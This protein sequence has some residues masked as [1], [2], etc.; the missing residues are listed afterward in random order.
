MKGTLILGVNNCYETAT[1]TTTG[2][3]ASVLPLA[4]SKTPIIAQTARTTSAAEFKVTA[5]LPNPRDIGVVT[6]A[7]HN[8]NRVAT[9]Q[10]KTY[11]ADTLINDSGV[12][13]PWCYLAE[14]E[15]YWNNKIFS[16]SIIN[17][18]RIANS[19]HTATYFLPTNLYA[20]NVEIT[21]T[22]T[23]N[24]DGFIEFGRIFI[25]DVIEP[26]YNAE[27]GD[28]SWGQ[29]DFSELQ[30]TKRHIKYAYRY[31]TIRT[32]AAAFKWLDEGEAAAMYQA[33]L[34]LGLV[35][36]VV[37]ASLKPVYR[38]IHGVLVPDSIWFATAFLG[39]FTALDALANPYANAYSTSIAVEEIAR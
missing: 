20:D 36:E 23:S 31:P 37:V 25:G 13:S 8:L 9:L 33:K 2:S 5:T 24:A 17:I 16:A 27:F 11:L 3:F 7:G 34:N 21:F 30:V 4:N 10:I 32:V 39:N 35:G 26:F 15:L 18:D 28:V 29:V 19:A 12:I 14:S 38:I 6:I 22:N 1:L